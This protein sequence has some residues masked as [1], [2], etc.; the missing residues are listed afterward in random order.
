M[1]LNE[2]YMGVTVLEPMRD[3]MAGEFST[4]T[5][6]FT[7]GEYG[8]DDGGSLVVCWKGVSDWGTPQFDEPAAPNYTTVTTTGNCK[9]RAQYAKFFRSFNNSI[10]IDVSG[11]YIK[12]GDT[13]SI[14]FGDRS[15]GS[16]GMRVQS[17]CE[18][19][20]E[21]KIFLD[22]YGTFRYEQMPRSHKLR[23]VAGWP[24][25]LQAVIPGSIQIGQPFDLLV[26]ALDE[27]GNPTGKYTGRVTLSSPEVQLD[28]LPGHVDFSESNGGAV[29]VRG[30]TARSCGMWHLAVSD[31]RMSACSNAGRVTDGEKY[32]L[33]WGDAHGQTRETVGTGLLEDYYA[34]A[35][36]KAGVDFT[37]WQGNDFEISDETWQNV[38]DQ[39]KRFHDDGRFVTL[40][41]YEWSGITPQG[42][43]HNVYFREDSEEFYPSSNWTAT[44]VDNG[45]N[46]NPVTEL[47]DVARRRGDMLLIQH[48]GGRYGNLD[49]LDSSVMNLIEV[50]SHHGTFEWFAFDA[51][52]RR[53]K[54][55]FVAA[56]DDHTG[57]PGL[58][59][60]LSKHGRSASAAFDVASG[61]TGVYARER[62]REAIWEALKARR[63]YASSFDRIF[64]DMRV[65][66]HFMGEEYSAAAGCAPRL[67]LTAGG[68]CPIESVT[69]FDWDKEIE[70]IDLLERDSRR[71][72]VRWSGVVYR[73]RGKSAPWDGMLYVD[74][75]YIRSAEPYAIDRLDQGIRVCTDKYVTW[76]SSTSGDYDGLVLD[77]EGGGNTVLRFSSAQG[78]V[79]V[80]LSDV[81]A[82]RVSVPMGGLN[83]KVEFERAVAELTDERA[84]ELSSTHIERVLAA[85]TGEHAFWARITQVNGNSAWISP[86]Y[87]NIE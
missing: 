28:G 72:R 12:K 1:R 87:V 60:P 54:V 26:R 23:V 31:G 29:W 62:T 42:G 64:A 33:L 35:R 53:L 74:G 19:E 79:D 9:L 43:D 17:F 16:V 68:S 37:G 75:G 15:A 65:D 86:V 45:N 2:R 50:H 40:L 63:C 85:N 8:I 52:R 57:R 3:V 32:R 80:R 84:L 59:Y 13:I 27:F 34:F 10:R 46:C 77:L 18:R 76:E 70:R 81:L 82:G 69:L 48:I 5:L 78:S 20:H 7:A 36:D 11:G 56:S 58:S 51:M 83:L 14:V 44:E 55:G 41:G 38:R 22:A 21:F 49:Y 24:H 61:F 67:T 47:Y 30:V 25:E 73:G 66:G 39:T 4:W 71:I 6:T